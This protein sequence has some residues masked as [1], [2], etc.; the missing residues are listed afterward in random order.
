MPGIS[1]KL[2]QF[3]LNIYVEFMKTVSNLGQN[4]TACLPAR[5]VGGDKP[6]LWLP[7]DSK[8][9]PQGLAP[10]GWGGS[11]KEAFWSV[12]VAIFFAGQALATHALQP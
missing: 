7:A 9:G 11:Q 10:E 1:G 6:G 4:F 12:K 2:K 3:P 8:R 5:R